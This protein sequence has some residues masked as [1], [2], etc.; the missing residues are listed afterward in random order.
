MLHIISYLLLSIL[1]I[2]CDRNAENADTLTSDKTAGPWSEEKASEWYAQQPWLVGT[3]FGPSNAINQLEMW[4]QETFDRETIERE[5]ALSANI[6]MNTHR[7]FL[8]NLLWEQDSAGFLD[9]IDQFLT[10]AERHGIKPMLVLFDGVW[11]PVPELGIQPEP[12]P[13]KHNSGWVQSPG[14]KYLSDKRHYPKLER[15]LKGVISRFAN[16]DRVLM[17]DLFN[18]PDNE[19]S[20]S[21]SELELHDKYDRAF[22]LL[23][24]AF[25]WA[26]EVNP[27]QPLTAGVWR[28]TIGADGQANHEGGTISEFMLQN[29]DII[30]F[31]S[32]ERPED[33]PRRIQYLQ[34]YNRPLV[35]TEYLARSRDNTFENMLPLFK[36]YRIGAYNW[37]FVSGKTNTIYPW[38]SWDSVYV[39]EPGLWHHDIFRS[40]LTAYREAEVQLIKVLTGS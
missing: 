5:L 29:S 40:D 16:D 38:D 7:V 12:I 25:Q 31:H 15:Y 4:Q 10:I 27:S 2:Q 30:S 37:G 18:E 36:K 8:H 11:H 34:R 33:V 6:G 39:D 9:R 20:A 21:Y 13:H 19:N 3:N 28:G 1:L 17:W 35:C 26:R 23:K 32:Y 14:A 22:D 24:A